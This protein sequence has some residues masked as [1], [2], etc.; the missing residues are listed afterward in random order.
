MFL[1]LPPFAIEKLLLAAILGGLIG[2]ER[3]ESNTPAGLRTNMVIALSTCLFTILSAYGFDNA[4]GVTDPTR[5]AAQIV[6]GVGF[7]GAGS[8]FHI[9]DQTRGLTT[10]ATI[11]LVA[12]VGM[13]V[14]IGLFLVALFT[15]AIVLAILHFLGPLSQWLNEQGRLRHECQCEQPRA[16]RH[17]AAKRR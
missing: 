1:N 7:L 6:S 10:A 11:W 13:A 9:R 5:I 2:I 12:G 8:I 16:A 14:G 15:T 4:D 17:R 3:G